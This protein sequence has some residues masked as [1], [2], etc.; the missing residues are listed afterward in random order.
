MHIYSTTE[1]VLL[2]KMWK[3][4]QDSLH[5]QSASGKQKWNEYL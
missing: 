4:I 5:V 1:V 2:P 3:G